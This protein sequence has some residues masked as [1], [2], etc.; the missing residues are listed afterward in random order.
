MEGLK[1]LSIFTLRPKPH[2]RIAF[3]FRHSWGAE[4][5]CDRFEHVRLHTLYV[6]AFSM[7]GE[8][9][10]TGT[11]IHAGTA[12]N[13]EILI[14]GNMERF[15]TLA[16]PFFLSLLRFGCGNKECTA[17]TYVHTDSASFLTLSHLHGYLA[18][19]EL[20]NDNTS[21]G[22]ISSHHRHATQLS[23]LIATFPG[24]TGALVSLRVTSRIAFSGQAATQTPQA[25]Q[26][27]F[28]HLISPD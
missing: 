12:E 11:C 6:D 8:S 4:F 27:D 26:S 21:D 13:T 3:T 10:F 15:G 7:D 25:S 22:Q 20:R 19:E 14:Y 18:F 1:A 9:L 24:R 5:F 23:L 28:S 16:L 2:L 17:R